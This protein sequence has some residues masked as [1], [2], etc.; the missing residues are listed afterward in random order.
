VEITG[1]ENILLWH[2]IGSTMQDIM[3]C[4]R[5]VYYPTSC[6]FFVVVGDVTIPLIMPKLK[7]CEYRQNIPMPIMCDKNAV[8]KIGF[9]LNPKRALCKE[10]DFFTKYQLQEILRNK[11]IDCQKTQPYFRM[12]P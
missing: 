9:V 12:M 2:D 3:I 7:L 6:V 1:K 4:I 10:T 8:S 11:N 5:G